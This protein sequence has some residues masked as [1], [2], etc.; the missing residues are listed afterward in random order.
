[1]KLAR[2]T[3]KDGVTARIGTDQRVTIWVVTG[4]GDSPV[5]RTA[6]DADGVSIPTLITFTAT[7]RPTMST[8]TVWTASSR[9]SPK[10]KADRI[11]PTSS[12]ARDG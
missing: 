1:M 11:K 4:T 10:S 8:S 7:V 6:E 5:R 3:R 9:E 2:D 12:C